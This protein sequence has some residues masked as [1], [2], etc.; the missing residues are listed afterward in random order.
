MVTKADLSAF[1]PS[2]LESIFSTLLPTRVNPPLPTRTFIILAYPTTA[3]SWLAFG[4]DTRE[5]V[6]AF[7]P[8]YHLFTEWI[9][10]A[11]S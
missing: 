7:F 2:V 9:T 6:F 10:V 11:S 8:L 4:I 1:Y 5:T 3:G